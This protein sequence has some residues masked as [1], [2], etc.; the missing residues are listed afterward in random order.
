MSTPLEDYQ[1]FIDGLVR[2]STS[3][4]ARWFGKEL[5]GPSSLKIK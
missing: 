5:V 3:V 4:S 1:A 2:L